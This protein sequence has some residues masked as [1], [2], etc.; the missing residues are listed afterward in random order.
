MTVLFPG[1]ITGKL[2]LTYEDAAGNSYEE[3]TEFESEIK[4]A[5]IQ[6]LKIEDDQEET[7]S[8]WYSVIAVIAVLLVSVILLLLGKLHKKKNTSGRNQK[9][10]C[11]LKKK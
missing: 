7:N 3:S 4:E 6:S 9:G 11:P 2:I 1:R 5:K 8:W 10:G